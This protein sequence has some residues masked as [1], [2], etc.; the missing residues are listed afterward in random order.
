MGL[1]VTAS[2]AIPNTAGQPIDG[3]LP[4]VLLPYQQK[5]IEDDSQLKIGEKSRRIGLTWAEAADNVLIAMADKSAGGQNVYYIGYNQDM[6]LEYIEACA[7]WAKAFNYAASEIE[8]GIWEEDQEDKHIK[9]FTIKF[10]KSGHRIVA[11]SSRPANLRGKQGVIVI[12]EAAFHDKLGEL[13]KAALALLI[14][15]G[16]VRVISTHD[17]EENPFCQLV[18]EIKNGTRKGSVHRTTFKEAVDYG[19]YERVCLRL[20]KPYSKAGEEKWIKEVYEF[21]GD[22]AVE[23]LDV[24]PK[25]GS[26]SYIPSI[27]IEQSMYDAPILRLEYDDAFAAMGEHLRRIDTDEWIKNELDPILDG[28]NGKLMHAFGQDFARKG[29]LSV[30]APMVISENLVRW[31]PVIIEMR[32]VPTRQQEQILWHIIG[33]LPRFQS[34]AMDATGNGETL[35]EYTMDKFGSRIGCIKL[36]DAFYSANMTAFK[37]A[38]ED[39]LIKIPRHADVRRDLRSISLQKGVPKI[40]KDGE[41]DGSDGKKRHA[42]SAVALFLAYF[43]TLMDVEIFDYHAVPK[44]HNEKQDRDRYAVRTT[45]GFK[46][47]ML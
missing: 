24:T 33:R 13:L 20:D 10:P 41:Y 9:T 44:R 42:D 25:A 37:A 45:A 28:L 12:D 35:A 43:A 29:H 26:G 19:L 8:E 40:D 21:Y 32:N 34:G 14:W 31:V 3:D 6:G 27:L 23:E 17:G 38:F 5:W 30:I 11:L 47:G 22:D 4:T 2:L 15:G 7:M 46:R 36:S 18:N 1:T 39:G 16:K